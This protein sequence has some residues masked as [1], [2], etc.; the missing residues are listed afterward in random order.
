MICRGCGGVLGRDCW[1]END[2]VAIT[3]MME[4]QQA[5]EVL[6]SKSEIE[7]LRQRI[8][9]I[10]RFLVIEPPQPTRESGVEE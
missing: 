1:N 4:Q 7:Y 10:E 2:C 3:H 6:H 5:Q 9:A 8:E